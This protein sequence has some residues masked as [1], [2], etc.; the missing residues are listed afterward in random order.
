M[1]RIGAWILVLAMAWAPSVG[2]ED[3]GEVRP[4]VSGEDVNVPNA[5][6]GEPRTWTPANAKSTPGFARGGPFEAALIK[7]FNEDAGDSKEIA[8]FRMNS[9]A[10]R[11]FQTDSFVQT[12]IDAIHAFKAAQ[13]APPRDPNTYKTKD[14]NNA[15][16]LLADHRVSRYETQHFCFWYGPDRSREGKELDDPQ[17]LRKA[18]EW[19]EKVWQ[20]N[21]FQMHAPMPYANDR[22]KFR[23]NVSLTHTG[24]PW[25]SGDDWATSAE[26]MNLMPTAMFYGSTVVPH[27]FTHVIQFYSGGFRES[28]SVGAFWE[29]HAEFSAMNFCPFYDD[30]MKEMM[31]NLRMGFQYPLSR[32]SNFPILFQLWEKR[33]TAPLVYGIWPQNLRKPDGSTLE[34]PAQTMVRLGE[35]DQI[36]PAG[37]TSFG[38]EIGE[39]AA[40]LVAMDYVNQQYFL[41]AT[42]PFRAATLFPLKPAHDGWLT[43]PQ[44]KKLHAYGVMHFRVIPDSGAK[45]IEVMLSGRTSSNHASWRLTLVGVN[46]ANECRYSP[47]ARCVLQNSSTPVKLDV[48]PGETYTI[49]VAATPMEYSPVRWVEPIKEPEISY[50]FELRV[51]GAGQ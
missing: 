12:D 22:E 42:Q 9:G 29:T 31:E 19:Y 30:D 23:V 50:P 5:I 46:A 26:S 15:F 32:Y 47:M 39:M 18:G 37:W 2:A 33:R 40:R 4:Y 49:A 13:P 1:S 11:A 27:E 16:S 38:D 24:L 34:D 17:Y 35:Q 43:P 41:D 14:F 25:L 28:D 8:V 10:V 21:Q 7:V 48:Q 36:L 44:D 45:T 3:P 20:W 6:N 51:V